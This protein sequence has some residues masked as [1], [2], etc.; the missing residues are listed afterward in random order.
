LRQALAIDPNAKLEWRLENLIMQERAR[1][2]LS[3][4]SD[5]F[6]GTPPDTLTLKR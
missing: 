1:W 5:L 6:L 3:R 2:L 4:V